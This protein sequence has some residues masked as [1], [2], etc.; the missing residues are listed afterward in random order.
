M[1][2][3]ADTR[4]R[5]WSIDRERLVR[6]ASGAPHR[7]YMEFGSVLAIDMGVPYR[8][9]VQLSAGAQLPDWADATRAGQWAAAQGG[10]QWVVDVPVE[11]LGQGAWNGLTEYERMGMY[12]TT[13]DVAANLPTPDIAGLAITTT[14]TYEQVV[15]AYGGW[16]DDFALAKLLVTPDDVADPER[17]FLVGLVNDEPIGCAFVWTIADTRYLSGIGVVQALRGRGYGLA[18]TTAA[19]HCASTLIDGTPASL[20]WMH[21][22]DEGAALYSRMGFELVDTEVQLG[23]PEIRINSSVTQ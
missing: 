14:P 20:V 17:S 4:D 21:S 3:P 1:V 19:A 13:H 5:L 11:L 8:W 16:M 9:G 22:T 7:S 23:M 2:L 10:A 15:A 18:L 6:N 12:A